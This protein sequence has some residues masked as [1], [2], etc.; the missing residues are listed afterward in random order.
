MTSG[1]RTKEMT[2]V[3]AMDQLGLKK[4]TSYKLTNSMKARGIPH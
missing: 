3:K 2:A 4:N 1:G